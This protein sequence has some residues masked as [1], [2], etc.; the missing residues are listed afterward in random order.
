MR[1]IN[2]IVI[3]CSATPEGKPFTADDIRRWHTAPVNR[4]G[5]GWKDIGYHY[6]V[7]LDG[8]VKRGRQESRIG[9]HCAGHNRD[10][11]GVCYVGGVAADGRTPKDTRTPEQRRAL[12]NLVGDLKARYPDSI[13]VGHNDLNKAK[14]CPCFKVVNI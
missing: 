14:A 13:V 7:E 12:Y 1:K 4:G 8:T 2:K 9:A 5:N 10:S 11:I 6:V 3:H